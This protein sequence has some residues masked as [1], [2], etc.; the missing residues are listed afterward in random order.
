MTDETI[1]DPLPDIAFLTPESVADAFEYRWTRTSN[2]DDGV[3]IHKTL[4][5]LHSHWRRY[6]YNEYVEMWVNRL[7]N[8]GKLEKTEVLERG[9]KVYTNLA[10]D[11]IIVLSHATVS[12]ENIPTRNIYLRQAIMF[13]A[14]QHLVREAII[15]SGIMLPEDIANDKPFPWY[16]F[17][18][19]E[20]ILRM[21]YAT[22]DH[23]PLE[24]SDTIF[25]S[26]DMRDAEN[27]WEQY[28]KENGIELPETSQAKAEVVVKEEEES[29]EDAPEGLAGKFIAA[30]WK[31]VHMKLEIIGGSRKKQWRLQIK[32]TD[33]KKF[34]S[35]DL[36]DVGFVNRRKREI[37]QSFHALH[38]FA[39]Y[40]GFLHKEDVTGTYLDQY[41]EPT[42]I[43]WQTF[44][45]H[46]SRLRV[47]LQAAFGIKEDPIK[48]MRD[49]TYGLE[50]GSL[51]I[52]D[53]PLKQAM[54]DFIDD[55]RDTR[56]VSGEAEIVTYTEKFEQTAAV[57][58]K[59]FALSGVEQQ[60]I[61]RLEDDGKFW[62]E[63]MHHTGSDDELPDS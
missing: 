37:K 16:R 45:K 12:K 15:R 31:K 33:D 14:T 7:S 41:G 32:H 35:Y 30:A 63:I 24:F 17:I 4:E 11:R 51:K 13:A 25:V 22:P 23:K 58:Q 3:F 61:Y 38:Q 6:T 2:D 20:L 18:D 57:S 28:A 19:F 48:R 39:Q 56:P 50:F 36:K 59:E 47:D 27:A 1:E 60:Q 42:T 43:K 21:L 55:G 53:T 8:D 10:V 62:G 40:G 54:S 9:R 44:K 52:T 46:I 34:E 29:T 5:G 26:L 49:G